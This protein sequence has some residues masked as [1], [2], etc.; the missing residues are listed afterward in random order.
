M[1]K[2]V[3]FL[4]IQIMKKEEYPDAMKLIWSVFMQYEAPD[5]SAEGVQAFR[6][7][8]IENQEFQG[9]LTL[10]G[11]YE[12]HM[13]IG[14]LATRNNGAH[15]ALLFVDSDYQRRGIGR[16]LL[17]EHFKTVLPAK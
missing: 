12:E 6:K 4:K 3:S 7:S 9:S 15:I 8:V 5:Y 13:L 1:L 17:R 10:Y 11:A 16:A 14:V 2:E